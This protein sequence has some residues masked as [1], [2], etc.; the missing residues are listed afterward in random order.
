VLSAAH[1]DQTVPLI[2]APS[3][4]STTLD[5]VIQADLDAVCQARPS[6][7]VVHSGT[8]LTRVLCSE[9]IRF[10]HNIPTIVID[11]PTSVRRRRAI[12]EADAAMTLILSGRADAVAYDRS[13][14]DT[15][16]PAAETSR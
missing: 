8:E 2:N 5:R 15:P 6:A 7:V 14:Q 12:D 16:N 13:A 4:N 10:T 3:Q 9:H 11:N 1:G